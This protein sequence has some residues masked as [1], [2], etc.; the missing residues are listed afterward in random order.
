MS[1][2][3]C[4]QTHFLE[5]PKYGRASLRLIFSSAEIVGYLDTPDHLRRRENRQVMRWL[6]KIIRPLE[7]DPR[8]L[9]MRAAQDGRVIFI[10]A[11]TNG[12]VRAMH[13]Q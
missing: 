4:D 8:P 6:G 2:S 7:R 3:N 12:T 9:V 1:L 13:F 10:G 5:L 11:A